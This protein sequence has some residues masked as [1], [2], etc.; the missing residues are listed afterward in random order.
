[1]KTLLTLSFLLAATHSFAQALEAGLWKAKSDFSINGLPLPSNENEECI[2]KDEVKD[3]K[4]TITKDLRKNNCTLDTWKAHAGK[5]EASL[6]C[7]SDGLEATGKIRGSYTT[8][9]YDLA[10][11]AN[12]TYQK[13]IPASAKLK[14]KGQWTK[15]CGS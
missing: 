10:G 14:L 15:T 2:T 11:E 8:K 4:A 9:S 7:K 13:S 12:G 6:T 1:M 3:I 5:L